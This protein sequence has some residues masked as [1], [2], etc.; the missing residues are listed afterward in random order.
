M[1]TFFVL[2]VGVLTMGIYSGAIDFVYGQEIKTL[3]IV[4]NLNNVSDNIGTYEVVVT[5]Y[6]DEILSKSRIINTST[7]TCPDDMESLCYSKAGTFSFPSESI[8][9]GSKLQACV[10][11]TTTSIEACADGIN[12]NRNS[13]ETIWVNLPLKT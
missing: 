10:K 7:Q 12:S 9:T 2:I 11:D 8:P 4:V 13:P 5:A 3:D 1:I 6:G